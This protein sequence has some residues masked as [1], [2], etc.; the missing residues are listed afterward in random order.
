MKPL[1]IAVANLMPLKRETEAQILRQLS[2]SPL[3]TDVT[4]LHMASHT[5]KNTPAEYLKANYSVL[6]DIRGH[7]Y[8]G[9][10]ITGAPV[11]RLP[12]EAVDYW[13]ELCELMDWA[14]G[15]VR[16]TFY[17]CWGAQAGLYYRYGVNKRE[18]P[19]KMFGI[20]GHKKL[21]AQDSPNEA[22]LRG[23]GDIFYAPHSRHTELVR[24]D[25]ANVNELEIL[26]ASDEAGFYL[27]ASKDRKHIFMTGHSE[28]D[29]ETLENE[30][31]RD[32]N[33][34]LAIAVP[35]NYFINNDPNN[36]PDAELTA[37]WQ[38]QA[39]LLFGNWLK[40]YVSTDS[41]I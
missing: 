12:F 28:Y 19:A 7:S 8:D 30:Y 11:E 41:V 27:L 20:F 32:L 37:K 6:K 24:E 31:R 4:W 33:K 35:K 14:D 10:I 13:S 2:Q 34:G 26:S 25:I 38:S 15:N 3:K 23:F 39:A 5:S 16:S 21:A 9:C 36:G 29:A 18:I 17:I 40:F 22:L 1:K